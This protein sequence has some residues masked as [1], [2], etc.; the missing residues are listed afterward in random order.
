MELVVI[1]QFPTTAEAAMARNRLAEEGITATL[2]DENVG[3]L[4]H[5]A[6]SF[7]EVK[8]MVKADESER[9]TEILKQVHDHTRPH[10]YH[11]E[12]TP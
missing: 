4:F 2:T 6:A 11:K 5:L 8:L 9:A 7:G 10:G 1:A 3:D 12:E